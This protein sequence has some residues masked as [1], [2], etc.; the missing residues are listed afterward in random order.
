M[1]KVNKIKV[2]YLHELTERLAF[3]Y[4]SHVIPDKCLDSSRTSLMEFFLRKSLTA[5]LKLF[6]QKISTRDTRLSSK[7]LLNLNATSE[8]LKIVL[9]H[10]QK[11]R[12][13][14]SSVLYT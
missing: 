2:K 13:S 5:R 10:L 8:N 14:G 1:F 11:Y 7:Y 9:L 3:L 12:L 4:F 6:L